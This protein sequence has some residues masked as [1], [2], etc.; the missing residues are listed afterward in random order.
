MISMWLQRTILRSLLDSNPWTSLWELN[1]WAM[2]G[3]MT[4]TWEENSFT[5]NLKYLHIFSKALELLTQC[6]IMVQ[7]NT[8]ATLGPY[9]GLKQVR[10]CGFFFTIFLKQILSENSP[11]FWINSRH[12]TWMFN[13]KFLAKAWLW[14]TTSYTEGIWTD[15]C[16]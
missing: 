7:G 4:G 11:L 12:A 13:F 10:T 9:K 16:A 8:V 2:K 3:E 6:Y 5:T 14:Y 1:P 15:F